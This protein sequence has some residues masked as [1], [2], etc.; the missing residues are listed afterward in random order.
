MNES[1]MMDYMQVVIVDG[2]ERVCS[3][4]CENYGEMIKFLHYC[5]KYEVDWWPHQMAEGISQ[6]YLDRNAG[7]GGIVTDYWIEYGSEEC[8]QCIYVDIGVETYDR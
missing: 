2:D 8:M 1:P 3:F 7:I 6:D 4:P 5:K